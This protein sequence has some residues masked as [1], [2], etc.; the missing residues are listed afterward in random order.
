MRRLFC[1]VLNEFGKLLDRAT[2]R[3]FK[4]VMLRVM[5]VQEMIPFH[6]MVLYDASCAYD[7]KPNTC[8]RHTTWLLVKARAADTLVEDYR[9]PS[10]LHCNYHGYLLNWTGRPTP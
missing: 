3:Q 9:R 2:N 8:K 10:R 4:L 7:F 6:S 5:K 1:A